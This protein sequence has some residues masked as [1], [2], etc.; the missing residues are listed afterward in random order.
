MSDSAALTEELAA[1]VGRVPGVM[2]IYSNEPVVAQ[3]VKATVE[4]VMEQPAHAERIA[5]TDSPEGVD[6]SLHIGVG[7]VEPAS[8]VVRAV[9]DEISANLTASGQVIKSIRIKV[10]HIG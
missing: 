2:S 8:A 10:G 9:Y 5:V 4:A 3:A 6:V 7:T 1:L